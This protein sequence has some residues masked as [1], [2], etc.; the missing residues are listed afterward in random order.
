MSFV[1][2]EGEYARENPENGV[3]STI[4]YE[5]LLSLENASIHTEL[6]NIVACST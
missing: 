6:V 4:E 1:K 3:Q 5:F 2:V